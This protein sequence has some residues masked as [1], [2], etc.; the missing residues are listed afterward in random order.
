MIKGSRIEATNTT[1]VGSHT[2]VTNMLSIPSGKTFVLTDIMVS[3][4]H[5]VDTNHTLAS[6]LPMKL[7]DVVGASGTAAS[8]TNTPRLTI[9]LPVIPVSSF[10]AASAYK[11]GSVVVHFT[12]G[13]EFE[14]GVTPATGDNGTIGTGCVWIAGYL[15]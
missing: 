2:I 7:Y 4:S 12:N 1:Y 5:S 6:S 3:G 13:P 11:R 15:R 10:E 14:N 9:N 8:G